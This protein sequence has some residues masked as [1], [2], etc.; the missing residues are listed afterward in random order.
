MYKAAIWAEASATP[1]V[2]Q[3]LSL[4]PTLFIDFMNDLSEIINA[5][6]VWL[7]VD[8]AMA[9]AKTVSETDCC[10]IQPDPNALG[11]WTVSN[12]LL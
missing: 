4:G 7:F 12:H 9:A 6:D 3:G 11:E 1:G 10:A 5:S 2:I 8:D